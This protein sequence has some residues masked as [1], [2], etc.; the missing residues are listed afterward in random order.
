MSQNVAQQSATS[1]RMSFRTSFR[2][3][4][5]RP[6]SPKVVQ[7]RS[8]SFKVAHSRPNKSFGMSFGM[9]FN[10]VN[11]PTNSQFRQNHPNSYEIEQNAAET[12]N[13]VRNCVGTTIWFCLALRG[14]CGGRAPNIPIHMHPCSQ[15]PPL[16]KMSAQTHMD[17]YVRCTAPTVATQCQTQPNCCAHAISHDV[18]CFGRVLHAFGRIRVVLARNGCWWEHERV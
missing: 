10:V 7:S 9:S 1:F 3:V 16:P 11:A 8:K 12:C 2:V 4:P 18:A 17:W 6:K 13:I 5:S 15:R 14:T